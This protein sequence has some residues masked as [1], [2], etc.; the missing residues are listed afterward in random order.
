MIHKNTYFITQILAVILVSLT[1]TQTGT[2]QATLP[3]NYFR[4]PV[5]YTISLSGSFGEVRKNHFHSGL[6]IRTDGV[7]GKP[8]RAA[9]DGYISRINISPYGFGKSL[10]IQHPNG[11]TTVY[12]HLNSYAGKI[13]TY[14][15]AQQYKQESFAIDIEVPAGA[16]PVKKGDLI[17]FSGNSGS[18]GGP[19]LHFE[20]RDG[21]TQDPMDPLEFG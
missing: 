17:A 11:Y 7:T 14:A 4:S 5:D 18:S 3:K 15:H 8:V 16:L 9:A 1:F 10:Y 21:G 12:A 19:H 13:S 20:I 2:G 6:D